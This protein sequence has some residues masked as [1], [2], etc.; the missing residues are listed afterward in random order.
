MHGM[1][2]EGVST[3]HAAVELAKARK[4]EMPITAQ[5]DAILNRGK[6][7]RDAIQELMTRSGKSETGLYQAGC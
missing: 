6:S 4:V 2:A 5:M 3:T 1:V 7:P